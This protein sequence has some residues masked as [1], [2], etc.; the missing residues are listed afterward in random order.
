MKKCNKRWASGYQRGSGNKNSLDHHLQSNVFNFFNSSDLLQIWPN[1]A[2]FIF[3]K[4]LCFIQENVLKSSCHSYCSHFLPA[5]WALLC[6]V[7]A[8]C[9]NVYWAV[10]QYKDIVLP[11]WDNPTVEIRHSCDQVIFCWNKL[12]NFSGFSTIYMTIF[13]ILVKYNR[14][15]ISMVDA[16]DL[17]LKHQGISSHNANL[18]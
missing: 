9:S 18:Y 8:E 5:W 11:V 10:F 6:Q 2:M 17:V 3:C 4:V 14:N 13:I 16:D 7:Q 12:Y 1:K 15:C